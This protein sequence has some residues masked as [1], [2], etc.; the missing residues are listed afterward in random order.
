LLRPS[1][2]MLAQQ[3]R[4]R[5]SSRRPQPARNMRKRTVSVLPHRPTRRPAR[6]N[7]HH[8]FQHGLPLSRLHHHQATGTGGE[9]ITAAADVQIR[10]KRWRNLRLVLPPQD[11]CKRKTTMTRCDHTCHFRVG[12]PGVAEA[13]NVKGGD[14]S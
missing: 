14:R 8:T 9:I 2:V 11:S 3:R 13:V 12:R 7:R 6:Q 5:R 4:A 1:S 10:S